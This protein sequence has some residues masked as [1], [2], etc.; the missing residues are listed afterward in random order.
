MKLVG[1]LI[2]LH[3]TNGN[4]SAVNRS[5]KKTKFSRNT[6][7][8]WEMTLETIN[9]PDVYPRFEKTQK[10]EVIYVCVCV[11]NCIELIN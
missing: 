1:L 5:M 9:E 6:R 2:I 11:L 3:F 7:E 4:Q 10:F 8:N